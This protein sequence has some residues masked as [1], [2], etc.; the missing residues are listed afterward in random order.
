MGRSLASCTPTSAFTRIRS[1]GR[2][3]SDGA[4]DPCDGV[5]SCEQAIA[6]QRQVRQRD[7]WPALTPTGMPARG[8]QRPRSTQA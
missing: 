5:R 2:Y 1:I 6:I 4:D 8:F 3:I 7:P